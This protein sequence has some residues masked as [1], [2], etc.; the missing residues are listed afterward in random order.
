VAL[1]AES[2]AHPGSTRCWSGAELPESNQ[3][4]RRAAA[5]IRALQQQETAPAGVPV[6]ALGASSGGSFVS[7]LAAAYPGLV[8]AV[9]LYISPVH[10]RFL[11]AQSLQVSVMF[12]HMPRDEAGARRIRT[13]RR[14]LLPRCPPAGA[15]A[16]EER[17]VEPTD[18][19]LSH[20]ALRMP[21]RL[22]PAAGLAL[23]SWLVAQGVLRAARKPGQPRA[24]YAVV[25]PLQPDR[26]IGI[27]TK[28]VQ[29]RLAPCRPPGCDLAGL[30]GAP[31]PADDDVLFDLR[32]DAGSGSAGSGDQP[33]SDSDD[34]SEVERV[35]RRA[36]P[37]MLWELLAEAFALHEMSERGIDDVA[38]FFVEH[39]S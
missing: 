8:R 3:D 32:A 25:E 22:T 35:Q 15:C 17:T 28:F 23:A 7:L 10:P 4:L 11:A 5:V 34:D 39:I 12:V 33:E 36:L 26:V 14:E 18:I 9:A 30:A 29:R 2:V 21:S 24:L 1:S 31:P 27:L 6:F 20:F 19:M 37:R 16:V 13:Q 38:V